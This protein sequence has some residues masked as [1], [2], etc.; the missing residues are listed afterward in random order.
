MQQFVDYFEDIPVVVLACLL[1]EPRT[2]SLRGRV[3]LP[4]VPELLPGRPGAGL[5]GLLQRVAPGTSKAALRKLLSIPEDV[6][7]SLTITLGRPE[8]NHGPL[9]RRPIRD[10]VY[11]DGWEQTVTWVDDPPESRLSRSEAP[12]KP[13]AKS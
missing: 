12:P 7:I 2:Q 3:D 11:E 1:T 5:R 8:G 10:M 6:A 4:G 9:R 13:K